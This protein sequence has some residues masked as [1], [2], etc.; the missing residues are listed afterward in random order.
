[1]GRAKIQAS[2]F[3]GIIPHADGP[4]A[5]HGVPIGPWPNIARRRATRWRRPVLRG[6]TDAGLTIRMSAYGESIRLPF[7]CPSM[8][9]HEWPKSETR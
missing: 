5:M 6:N 8:R 9:L 3:I 4:G 1:M 2:G 7:E